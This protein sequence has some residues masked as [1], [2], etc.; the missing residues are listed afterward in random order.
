MEY[1]DMFIS[2][3]YL[4]KLIN[5]CMRGYLLKASFS[6]VVKLS[7]MAIILVLDY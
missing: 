6:V 5:T 7:L 4:M 2:W 1:F 3:W